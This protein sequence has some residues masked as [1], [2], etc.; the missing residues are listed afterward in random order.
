MWN[1]SVWQPPTTTQNYFCSLVVRTCCPC[2]NAS[3]DHR[4]T[5]E[6]NKAQAYVKTPTTTSNTMK[7]S[8]INT[9]LTN[10]REMQQEIHEHRESWKGEKQYSKDAGTYL[11]MRTHACMLTHKRTHLNTHTPAHAHTH[12]KWPKCPQQAGPVTEKQ[13]TMQ[14]YRRPGKHGQCEEGKIRS[15]RGRCQ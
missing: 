4:G 10:E 8:T 6:H 9:W 7:A 2:L 15:Q 14:E 3:V 11:E 12:N 5:Y 13:M 1:W